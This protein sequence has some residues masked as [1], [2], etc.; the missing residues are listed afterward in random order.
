M[1]VNFAR[2]RTEFWKNYFPVR[3]GVKPETFLKEGRNYTNE[4]IH[5]MSK[6]RIARTITDKVEAIINDKPY[7]LIDM[8]AGIGGNVLE[9][10]SRKNC[11]SV[12]AFER[13]PMRRLMLQRNIMGYKFGDK[14]IVPNGENHKDI[15]G[16]TGEEDFS[17]Y[18]NAVFFFDP[19]WLPEN[20]K[21]AGKDDYKKN[22][23]LKDM[24]VG[25]LTLEEWIIKLTDIAYMVVIRGP[26]GYQLDSVPEWT[27]LVDDLG[28]DGRLISCIPNQ[29]VK[30]APENEPGEI[31]NTS[32]EGFK[33]MPSFM[34]KL[35]PINTALANQY[36]AFRNSCNAISN[37][38]A[39]KEAKCK[40]FVKWGFV[41]SN[42][43]DKPDKLLSGRISSV[44]DAIKKDEYNSPDVV[45][46]PQSPKIEKIEKYKGTFFIDEDIPKEEQVVVFK[47]IPKATKGLDKDSTE[48]AAEFQY[49]IKWLLTQFI[50]GKN[51]EEIINNLVQYQY[52]IIWIKAFTEPSYDPNIKNNYDS[53]EF[54]GDRAADYVFSS[55][56][57]D[58]F[59][60]IGENPTATII[61]NYK[62]DYMSNL[63]QIPAGRNLGLKDWIRTK[64]P[65]EDKMYEDV[66]ESFIGALVEN[67]DNLKGTGYGINLCFK[68]IKMITKNIRLNNALRRGDYKSNFLQRLEVYGVKGE[69][70]NIDDESHRPYLGAPPNVFYNLKLS[71]KIVSKLENDG[72]NI[73]E[74]RII[75]TGKGKS[76][77]EAKDDA[78]VK[79]AEFLNKIGLTNEYRDKKKAEKDWSDIKEIN[80]KLAQ[81]AINKINREGYENRD[82][83]TKVSNGKYFAQLTADSDG[84]PVL[85][86]SGLDS[87]KIKA[88]IMAIQEFINN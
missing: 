46:K 28:N 30:G 14:A 60:E 87:D 12:M 5:Y 85:L 45:D 37:E 18:K 22:Y 17:D 76:K 51:A 10:L 73:P 55:I 31:I 66:F 52:L 71:T 8:T 39:M 4:T 27:Y 6:H 43:G 33:G 86:G 20:Y 7:F 19:P 34:M 74:S 13:D 21:N 41:D 29:Y 16:I 23:I 9:F 40:I 1:A 48:W 53:L 81:Q 25:N 26:P 38:M 68:F 79:G 44:E 2:D 62:K 65:F 75:A 54:L 63:W 61:T 15:I 82:L 36:I 24:K 80:P 58:K 77:G 47:E 67:G 70:E 78:Y 59:V 56:L 35:K 32:A 84:K 42:P 11:A 3:N 64:K 50:I 83:S 49:Y 88:K 72:F 57:I 69:G